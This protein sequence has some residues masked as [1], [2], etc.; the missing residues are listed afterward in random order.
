MSEVSYNT[1]SNK[2]ATTSLN[3]QKTGFLWHINDVN[4][5]KSHQNFNN[6]AKII[7]TQ[8]KENVDNILNLSKNSKN[9]EK[10]SLKNYSNL[11]ISQLSDDEI[12]LYAQESFENEFSSEQK[13]AILEAFYIWRE[14][15]IT[16]IYNYSNQELFQKVSILKD[17][18]FTL[19]ERRKLLESW[20]YWEI[21]KEKIFQLDINWNSLQNQVDNLYDLAEKSKLDYDVLLNWIWKETNALE[22]LDS[23]KVPLK[24]KEN[25]LSKI[26]SEYNWTDV[27]KVRDLLRWSLVYDNIW[28][29]QNAVK[30][31]KNNNFV[32]E[33]YINNRLDNVLQNDIL[34][35]IRFKNWF[36]WEV[37]L[38]LKDTLELK[39][40]W[41]LFDKSEI[42]FSIQ[43]SPKNLEI[44][45]WLKKWEYSTRILDEKV[46][47]PTNT[48]LV[49]THNIYEIRRSL[50]WINWVFEQE[51]YQKLTNIEK[52]LNE[53]IRKKYE[54][55]TWNK[56]PNKNIN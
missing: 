21:S 31:F 1:S 30:L 54:H 5:L 47:L 24:S 16:W 49:N 13:L 41:V 33:V 32:Q 20:I 39:E 15:L 9:E 8:S 25:I 36:V 18:W 35:N 37:Q 23:Q 29:L 52:Y 45:E 14:R 2:Y 48:E 26:T 43:F 56:F 6:K 12:I 34:V 11:Q 22:I 4:W 42:D 3:S 55:R 10:I 28:D 27:E 40:K 53:I 19:F 46:K 50:I 44:F 17:S 38:H 51:L 7:K